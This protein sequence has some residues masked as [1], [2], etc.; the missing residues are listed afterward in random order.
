MKTTKQQML[1][2]LFS[3]P[4]HIMLHVR[5]LKKLIRVIIGHKYESYHSKAHISI[6]M[7]RFTNANDSLY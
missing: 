3:P 2:L 6:L 7:R 4:S 5:E 1:F